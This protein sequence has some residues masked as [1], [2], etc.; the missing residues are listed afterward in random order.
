[1]KRSLMVSALLA[2]S[3]NVNAGWKVSSD[4]DEMTNET[5]NYAISDSVVSSKKQ[6]FPYHDTRSWIGVGCKKGSNA[7]VFFGFSNQPNMRDDKTKSGYSTALRL[8]RWD[9][10]LSDIS[11][12]QEWGSKFILVQNDGQVINRLKSHSSV[13]LDMSA[14]H[15]APAYFKYSLKGSTK[16]INTILSKCNVKPK[17]K[18]VKQIIKSINPDYNISYSKDCKIVKDALVKI[19]VSVNDNLSA[20]WLKAHREYKITDMH[21]DKIAPNAMKCDQ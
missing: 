10:D 6:G 3:F 11:M 17:K 13:K 4:T 1:M 20:E 5:I 12:K 16:S 2:V 9:N 21:Y 15:S 18:E 19:G 8:I 7:W 14:W